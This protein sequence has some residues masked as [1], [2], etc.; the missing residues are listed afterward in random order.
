MNNERPEEKKHSVL[1]RPYTTP[2]VIAYGS[3]AKLTRNSSGS[4]TDGGTMG[5]TM[6]MTMM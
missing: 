4:V 5:N 2:R 1:K 3:V 6:Q